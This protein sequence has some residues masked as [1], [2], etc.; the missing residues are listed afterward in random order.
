MGAF[1]QRSKSA[2]LLLSL[3]ISNFLHLEV[4]AGSLVKL[5]TCFNVACV[6]ESINQNSGILGRLCKYNITAP[7][8]STNARSVN[9]P[10]PKR[11][12]EARALG[13]IL[14]VGIQNIMDNDMR[15]HE[16]HAYAEHKRPWL[17]DPETRLLEVHEWN[18]NFI[19]DVAR[20]L[21]ICEDAR[22]V[23]SL[24]RGQMRFRQT[25][26]SMKPRIRFLAGVQNV[27]VTEVLQ[28]L[29]MDNEGKNAIVS[30]SASSL[31]CK[32][33]GDEPPCEEIRF[34]TPVD[35]AFR[36][37]VEFATQC[38]AAVSNLTPLSGDHSPREGRAVASLKTQLFA[39]L[40]EFKNIRSSI[41]DKS[42]LKKSDEEIFATYDT[43]RTLYHATSDIPAVDKTFEEEELAESEFNKLREEYW[44]T[45]L[46]SEYVV[47]ANRVARL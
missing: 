9:A 11:D 3:G 30:C 10:G 35:A 36:A 13:K 44:Q 8:P 19:L 28:Q 12:K 20:V 23:K 34:A 2:L 43:I 18:S 42:I 16:T 39:Y 47:M 38:I 32:G 17:N 21:S 27:D 24:L 15:P 7:R 46:A 22:Q 37:R 5:S 31:V 25:H 45:R 29:Q 6:A 1:N 4:A 26:H 14:D 33:D 40:G 41:L